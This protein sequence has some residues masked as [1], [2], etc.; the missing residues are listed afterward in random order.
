[1]FSHL[2]WSLQEVAEADAGWPKEEEE[3]DHG[4]RPALVHEELPAGHGEED[5]HQ[6]G[7]DDQEGARVPKVVHEVVPEGRNKRRTREE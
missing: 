5:G 4:L 7:K 2:E 3:E 1:M 6:H